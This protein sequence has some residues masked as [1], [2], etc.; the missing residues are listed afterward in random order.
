MVDWTM[1]K[2]TVCPKRQRCYRFTAKPDEKYQSYFMDRFT[3][4]FGYEYFIK[5]P[6]KKVKEEGR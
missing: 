1:C 3:C 6:E 4:K 5:M 2:S